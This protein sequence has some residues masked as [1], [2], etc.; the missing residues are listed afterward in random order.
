MTGRKSTD[1][2]THGSGIR[3]ADDGVGSD[4]QRIDRSGRKDGWREDRERVDPKGE[5]RDEGR[6]REP[7]Q[8]PSVP[9]NPD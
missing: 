6:E 8:V 2:A 3:D 9:P 1:E 7:R 5:E 4:R